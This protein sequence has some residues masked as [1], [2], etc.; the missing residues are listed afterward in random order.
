VSQVQDRARASDALGTVPRTQPDIQLLRA[1]AVLAVVFFHLSSTL[2]PGGYV[3]VDVFFVV[4]GYLITGHLAR[5][6]TETGRI[7]LPAFWARR[8]RRL[9]PAALL[10]LTVT[11]ILVWRFAPPSA[12]T[13]FFTETVAAGTSWENWFLAGSSVDYLAQGS[14]A[15]PVQHF[16][17]LSVEEQFYLGW[18]LVIALCLWWTGRLRSRDLRRTLGVALGVIGVA[19]LACSVLYTAADPAPAYF[20]TP[21][22]VWEFAAGG[23]LAL[24]GP[25]VVVHRTVWRT[26]SGIVGVALLVLALCAY[27]ERTPF[28]GVAAAL[29][30][31]GT[32]LVIVGGSSTHRWSVTA[33]ARTRPS[34][35]LGELSYALYLWHWPLI[36]VAPW[37]LGV[38]VARDPRRT[39][40][41]ARPGSRRSPAAPPRAPDRAASR[42]RRGPRAPTARPR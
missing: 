34:L 29:P 7:D 14:A 12:W 22:R 41:S 28:P 40:S 23:L 15:S 32:L 1:I 19:S 37:V 3:G 24:L 4:S 16:W 2:L 20:V 38:P 42:A 26:A 10:V 8:I 9:L 25:A 35:L 21:T 30:V 36:V 17:S 27:T 5:Q 31:A 18:P 33:L 11:A 13:Q 39:A 6:A